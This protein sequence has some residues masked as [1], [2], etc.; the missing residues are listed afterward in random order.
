V[1]GTVTGVGV[2][3][4]GVAILDVVERSPAGASEL[5]RE[6]GLSVS[7]AHRLANALVAHGLLRRDPDGRFRLGP[8]FATSVLTEVAL[9]VLADLRDRTGESAQL[10]VRRGEH[11]LCVAAVDSTAELRAALAVGTL[12]PLPLGSA[13]TALLGETDVG[14]RGWVESVAERAPG[15][16]SVSAPVRLHGEVAAAVCLSGPL[17]RLGR[18]PGERY[19][20]AVVGAARQVETAVHI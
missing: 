13:A 19:G 1:G 5:A 11:R 6:T 18:R 12:L 16:G 3:D 4:K 7:T 14:R 9:P 8:R 2:L 20:Q 17:H 15:V 10:W